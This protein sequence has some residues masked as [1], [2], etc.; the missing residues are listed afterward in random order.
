M[1]RAHAGRVRL[2]REGVRVAHAAPDDGEGPPEGPARADP[3]RDGEKARYYPR[4][5]PSE[6]VEQSWTRF[7]EALRP[8]HQA[9]KLGAILFQF[10]EWFPPSRANRDYVVECGDRLEATLPGVAA[11]IEFRNE[12]WMRDDEMQ[13]R[14][15]GLLSDHGLPFVCVDMPQGFQTSIPPVAAA[16]APLAMVRFHG[17]RDD[18]WG[19]RAVSV[20]DKFGY[21]YDVARAR[22]VGAEDRQAR[23]G[24]A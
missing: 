20:H 15:L 12:R 10:P 7:L 3:E 9:S 22:R 14:T 13:E 6:V 5:L 2:Q 19:K 4:D 23:V 21:D 8:L 1:G 18:T 16:T 11:A 24:R 17:R